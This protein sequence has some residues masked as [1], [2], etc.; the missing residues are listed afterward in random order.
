M[1]THFDTSLLQILSVKSEL[2]ISSSSSSSSLQVKEKSMK[3]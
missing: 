1:I 3:G 2:M